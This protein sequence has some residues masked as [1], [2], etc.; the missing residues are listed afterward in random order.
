MLWEWEEAEVAEPLVVLP[1]ESLSWHEASV[2]NP[3]A[4][5]AQPTLM[6]EGFP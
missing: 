2:C 4:A 5:K 6:I 1:S 3:Q